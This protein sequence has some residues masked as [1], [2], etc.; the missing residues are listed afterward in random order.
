MAIQISP[1]VN[2]TEIDLTTVVPSVLTTAGAFSGNFQWG[3]ANK[4]MLVDNEITL[5]NTFG[6]PDANSANAFFTAANF[7]AY[8]NNLNVVRAVNT[9]STSQANNAIGNGGAAGLQILNEDIYLTNYLGGSANAYGW[10]AARYPGTLGNSLGVSVCDNSTTFS[11]WP[12]KSL[13]TQTPSTSTYAAAVGGQNDEMH[14]VV[15]DETGAITGNSG[16]VIETFG[17]VSKG[18]DAVINGVSNYWKQ[19]IFNKSKYIYAMDPPEYNSTHATWGLTCPNTN[20]TQLNASETIQLSQGTNP[21][22]TD[23]ALSAGYSLFSNK[24]AVSVQLILTGDADATVQNYIY[25]NVVTVR[26]DC[27]AFVSPPAN[28][29][30]NN[31]GSESSSIVNYFQNTLAIQSSYLVAD[32]NWKYQFDKY[33][34]IYRWVPLNG[35]IAGLCVNTDAVADPWFSPAGFNRGAI[36]NAIKLAWNP[37]K[38]YRDVL[39][40]A[41]IN[42]IVSFP[43]QGIILYGDKTLQAKP[44]AFDRINVRRLFLV[45]EKAIS[46]AAQYSLFEFN[47]SFTQAQF[48]NLVTPFLRNVQGRRGIT[49]F[50]VQCDSTN[51]TP[52]VINAN[53]FV[54]SIYVMPNHS[55]NFIQLNFVAVNTGVDFSTVVG[56]V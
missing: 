30:I 54:G 43:G 11:T 48:V 12:Y 37:S 15:F 32:S 14:I 52:A 41:G 1:G 49:N 25:S 13:F 55:T 28:T 9:N 46:T 42:P 4:I 35:D 40:A 5:L 19:V 10:F 29:V 3:P 23:A 31:A 34:N 6:G 7:L 26:N 38:P 16:Q 17:F 47:D 24:E 44:S 53:Q 33:N 22:T 2:S 8:G 56:A 50:Y 18:V 51:N 39:Y 20:F 45:L 21:K 27:I 36:K